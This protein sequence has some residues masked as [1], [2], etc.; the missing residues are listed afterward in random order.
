MRAE[1]RAAGELAERSSFGRQSMA[2]AGE[3]RG[4]GARAAGRRRCRSGGTA[5]GAIPARGSRPGTPGGSAACSTVTRAAFVPAGRVASGRIGGV[6]LWPGGRTRGSRG[7]WCRPAVNPESAPWAGPDVN[8]GDGRRISPRTRAP[9]RGFRPSGTVEPWG[10]A[11]TSTRRKW[12]RGCSPAG[13]GLRARPPGRRPCSCSRVCVTASGALPVRARAHADPGQQLPSRPRAP[14]QGGAGC[15]SGA[16][17]RAAR[18]GPSSEAI[19]NARLRVC[20]TPYCS[21]LSTPAVAW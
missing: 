2:V 6:R 12:C 1:A 16:S 5:G 14:R 19:R 11:R 8:E 15:R 21:A 20:G 10:S 4:Q 17:G 13:R 9:C 18:P 7:S 3:P